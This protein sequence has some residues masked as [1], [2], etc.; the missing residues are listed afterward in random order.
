[1][2]CALNRTPADSRSAADVRVPRGSQRQM[3]CY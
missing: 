2:T 1:M 3:L